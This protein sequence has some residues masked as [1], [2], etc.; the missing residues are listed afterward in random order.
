MS[1]NRRSCG[2]HFIDVKTD[3]QRSLHRSLHSYYVV[4]I[5]PRN[6]VLKVQISCFFCSYFFQT[7]MHLS[8]ILLLT[9]SASRRLG[10]MATLDKILLEDSTLLIISTINY[11]LHTYT[12]SSVCFTCCIAIFSLLKKN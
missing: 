9:G 3:P 10:S 6:W 11:I 12:A 1:D 4:R 7:I 5:S 8:G 2:N